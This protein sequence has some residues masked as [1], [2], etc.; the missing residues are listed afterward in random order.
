MVPAEGDDLQLILEAVCGD[1]EAADDETTKA[2]LQND[3]ARVLEYS[4]LSHEK[5]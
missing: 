4:F 5:E 3:V 1:G 2:E